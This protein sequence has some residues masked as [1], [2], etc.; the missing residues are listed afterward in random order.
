MDYFQNLVLKGSRRTAEKGE[1]I[2]LVFTVNSS[3]YDV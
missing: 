3:I 1:E 2:I